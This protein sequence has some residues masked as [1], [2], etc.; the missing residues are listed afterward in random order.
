MLQEALEG[1]QNV[2]NL[3]EGTE[4][5]PPKSPLD[6]ISFGFIFQNG[7]F[8]L[9]NR[10]NIEEEF[11]QKTRDK[12]INDLIEP[13]SCHEIDQDAWIEEDKHSIA[14]S[15]QTRAFTE[16][17]LNGSNDVNNVQG[18]H[19]RYEQHSYP[20]DQISM[21]DELVKG[22]RTLNED[23]TLDADQLLYLHSFQSTELSNKQVADL[24]LAI[25][26]GTAQTQEWQGLTL[27]DRRVLKSYFEGVFGL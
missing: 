26:D 17:S 7:L 16:A 9:S 18:H 12:L 27:E 2:M 6:S 19:I 15:F 10:V 22:S 3:L 23:T 21:N 8:P 25:V 13:H 11:L 1:D 14:G 5:S 20:N 24:V 4:F